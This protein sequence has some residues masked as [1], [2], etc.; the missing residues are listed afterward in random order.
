MNMWWTI[1]CAAQEKM[2][3]HFPCLLGKVI[4]Y[5]FDQKNRIHEVSGG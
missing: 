5:D 2:T 3:C 1:S 4:E